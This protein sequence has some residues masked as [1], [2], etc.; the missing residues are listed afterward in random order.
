MGTATRATWLR[1]QM[2]RIFALLVMVTAT[3]TV[4]WGQ[5]TVAPSTYR[6][7]PE[8]VIT[9]QIY[10]NEQ[11]NA[12]ITVGPDGNISAPFVGTVRAAGK[13]TKELEFELGIL[14]AEKL[15]LKEPIVSVTIVRFREMRA[16]VN[17]FVSRPG[18]YAV[19][20]GDR[21]LDLLAKAG[22]TSTDGRA[23]LRR[24]IFKRKNSDESIPIDLN[25]MLLRNDNTQNYEIQDGDSLLVPQN[26][27]NSVIIGGR[28]R[29]PGPVTYREQLR[30]SEVVTGAGEIERRSRMSRVQ[31]FRKLPGGSTKF[32]NITCN[33]VD[34]HDGKDPR[35]DILLQPGD[36]IYVPDS[37][38]LDFGIIG[39]VTNFLFY[40]D[41]FG[42]DPFGF[43]GR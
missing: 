22:G 1:T 9:V 37:G 31:V 36:F 15:N 23:D 5:A 39:S 24:A 19:R 41:R 16:V 14:Y 13:T 12:T 8:D 32:L 34:Y 26:L 7:Q 43:G 35:Q 40:L 30:L 4:A 42:L 33:L 10:R 6:L 38:N 11:V 18:E 17:G 3:L 27:Q 28:V 21:I 2:K 20:H 29:Q 25:A